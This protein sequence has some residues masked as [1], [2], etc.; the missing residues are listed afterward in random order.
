MGRI[1]LSNMLDAV[2]D[3]G[4]QYFGRSSPEDM[5]GSA[6]AICHDLMSTPGEASGAA[7][8]RDIVHLYRQ[9]TQDKKLTFL[10]EV[11]QTFSVDI[12]KVAAAASA[13]AEKR[14]SDALSA[15]MREIEPP[16]QELFRRIN[17]APGGTRAIIGMRALIL[18]DGAADRDL[19][20]LADDLK[21]LLASWFNRGFLQFEQIDWKTPASIL[22][23]L[24]D[25]EAVH[26]IKGWDDLRRR[27]EKDRRCFAFFHPAL[28]EEPLIF[29]EVALTG[30]IADKIGSLLTAPV[31]MDAPSSADT[32]VFYSISNCQSGLAGIS[33]GNF[34][35]KQ[36]ADTLAK[37]F[38][39]MKTFV[40][41]SP[42]PGFLRWLRGCPTDFVNRVAGNDIARV[43]ET[44]DWWKDA[45]RRDTLSAP[46]LRLAAHYLVNERKGKSPLDPV[47]RFHLGN[48]ASVN[49][50]NWAA[51]LSTK[52]IAQSA[53]I[54]VNYR[55]DP[56]TI[57]VNHESFVNDDLIATSSAVRKHL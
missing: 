24:I 36:V 1:L 16:R 19:M 12:D 13:V 31:D 10:K 15:L 20:N 4:R 8:A 50:I 42:I 40:T 26:E 57:I 48:G 34:L 32:A 17:M 3:M 25:Y 23:K 41:L 43:F 38:P 29:V 45:H 47:A 39:L 53:G 55:Y 44:P 7:L 11:S 54:M 2:A 28:P 22:E 46:L 30:A 49:G 14:S 33:F 51:D 27:L 56:D 21:H 18:A 37:E 5:G 9:M 35:I 6:I 52:G